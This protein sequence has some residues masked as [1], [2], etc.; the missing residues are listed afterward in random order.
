[1]NILLV[2]P[3]FP[4][5]PK[6]KN[7]RDFLPIGLLK[8]AT[9]HRKRG[10]RVKLVRGN[11]YFPYFKPKQ[12]KITSLFTYWSKYVWDAVHFYKEHYPKAKVIVGGIYASLM[13]EHCKQSGCDKVFVGIHKHAENYEPAYDLVNV[14]YQI[15]HTTR[16]CIRRCKFCGTWKIEPKFAY[17][18][19][20]KDEICSNRIIF[21]DNNLLAN[22]YIKEIITELAEATNNGRAVY[23]ESQCGIDGRLLTQELADLLKK[24]RFINPRIAWDHQFEDYKLIK[25]QLDILVNAGYR[26]SDIYV[27]MIYN[28][29]IPF[30][31]MEKKRLKCWEWG[32]QI[33]DCRFRPLDQTFDYYNTTKKQ[34]ANDY[35]IHPKWIDEEIKQFRRN[36]RKHNICVRQKLK[37]YSRTLENKKVSKKEYANIIRLSKEQINKRLPDAWF[38]D[39]ISLVA[40]RLT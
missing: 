5:P 40:I 25:R 27:F 30:K 16:G 38:P 22:P 33:A 26:T 3:E 34:T 23:S 6:S 20:I 31:E 4:I 24:A 29:D 2:E 28:W 14:D 36:V 1:M 13:P 39:E 9:Y 18:R 19:S 37:F 21:Y 17:K 7:H 35:Y 32:V 12:I 11:D 15:I 8:L 10:D